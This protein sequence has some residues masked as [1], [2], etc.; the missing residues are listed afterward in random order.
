MAKY[1]IVRQYLVAFAILEFQSTFRLHF[2]KFA[3]CTPSIRTNF[4]S[5]LIIV[6]GVLFSTCLHILSINCSPSSSISSD[7]RTNSSSAVSSIPIA[8]KAIKGPKSNNHPTI[9]GNHA[10]LRGMPLPDSLDV[11][12]Q[13]LTDE[14]RYVQP[15]DSHSTSS[16]IPHPNPTHHTDINDESIFQLDLEQ[17]GCSKRTNDVYNTLGYKLVG[18]HSKGQS[19]CAVN[20][21]AKT[22]KQQIRQTMPRFHPL[23][24][25]CEDVTQVAH[26]RLT[27]STSPILTTP[28]T[29]LIGPSLAETCVDC[30]PLLYDQVDL[31][32]TPLAVRHCKMCFDGTHQPYSDSNTVSISRLQNQVSWV[33]EE[34]RGITLMER[35]SGHDVQPIW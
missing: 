19:Y 20:R 26:S 24:Y 1:P 6:A 14:Y 4:R 32:L 5:L 27:I 15:Q 29:P 31:T 7:T 22:S 12:S 23:Q 8:M 17:P 30:L 11:Y 35:K 21:A 13:H 2:L 28:P 25:V 18:Q 16:Y 34:L 10:T 3:A 9:L 33:A